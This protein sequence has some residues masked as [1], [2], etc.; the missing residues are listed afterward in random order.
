MN[1]EELT[2]PLE[3][4]SMAVFKYRT[5]GPA[6]EH[7]YLCAICRHYPAVIET[8]RGWLQPCWECQKQYKMIRLNW[9]DR[10]ILKRGSN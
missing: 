1:V 7:N 6:M 4:I 3:K 9:F 8:W 10:F 2:D 5:T